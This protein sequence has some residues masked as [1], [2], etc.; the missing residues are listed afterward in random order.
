MNPN[1]ESLPQLKTST[2]RVLTDLNSR[3]DFGK[4]IIYRVEWGFRLDK[5]SSYGGRGQYVGLT[6]QTLNERIRQ[7][8][9]SASSLAYDDGVVSGS[10]KTKGDHKSPRM[11]Y[12]ALRV[13][14]GKKNNLN[15]EFNKDY[16]VIKAIK[17]VNLFDLAY[18]EIK[19]I[20]GKIVGTSYSRYSDYVR[21][22]IVRGSSENNPAPFNETEGGEGNKI[23]KGYPSKKEQ[24]MAALLFIKEG[25]GSTEPMRSIVGIGKKKKDKD[26]NMVRNTVAEDVRAVLE[27]FKKRATGF[28]RLNA[29]SPTK[30]TIPGIMKELGV[31]ELIG[32]NLIVSSDKV[33]MINITLRYG[34]TKEMDLDKAESKNIIKDLLSPSGV[35]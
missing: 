3:P 34:E 14:M 18:E 21:S 23:N 29:V 33:R 20:G 27:Y 32:E 28:E 9:K 12:L 10:D 24:V 25:R 15:I 17:H 30:D 5:S 31:G 11:F 26:G 19:E 2:R 8:I 16:R 13:A 6:V 35:L 4:G 22:G 7:H 1:S